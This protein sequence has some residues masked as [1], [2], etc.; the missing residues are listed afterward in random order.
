MCLFTNTSDAAARHPGQPARLTAGRPG[1]ILRVASQ[2]N[3]MATTK[4][5]VAMATPP[6]SPVIPRPDRIT[7]SS[8][9][10]WEP[11]VGYSRAVRV[12]R[13][14]HVSGTTATAPDGTIVGKGDAYAQAVQALSNIRRALE[15][16][17]ASLADVVRTRTY[18]TNIDDWERVGRAHGEVFGGIRPTATMVEVQRLIDPAMLVEI[19]AEAYVA[20]VNSEPAAIASG[21]DRWP[22]LPLESWRET[23]ATLHMWTQIVGKT[24]LALA[25]PVN[26]WWHVPLYVTACGL[27]T[28]AIPYDGGLFDVEFD[29]RHHALHIRTSSGSTRS[30]A[31]APR[32]V[33]DFYV[34]YMASLRELGIHV[35]IWPVPVE[36]P[37]PLPFL[38]D[39]THASYEPAAVERLHGVLREA[40]RVL[41]DFRGRFIG[42]A[43]PVHFFWGSFDLCTTRF[44]GRRAPPRPNA[45]SITLEAYSHEVIS[46][47]F[48]PGSGPVQEPAFYAYAAPEPPGFADTAIA[49]PGALYRRDL[50]EFIL[51]YERV[52]TASSPDDVLLGFLEATYV[53]GAELGHWDREALERKPK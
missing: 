10:P 8:G 39:R 52:R 12:G 28:S 21:G 6:S 37:D 19:E 15:R 9:T 29:F 13:H 16:A 24:R 38:E 36:I 25:A 14:V 47:G 33:A 48:W 23:Y 40:D 45:D 50:G 44:S 32:A 30:I 35:R 41:Q 53:A 27:S 4:L 7:V 34:E 2:E 51:P 43:S 49:V 42:K 18:V 1:A 11:I 31:L 46:A 3:P 22:P 5:D 20:P 26:H 17:G